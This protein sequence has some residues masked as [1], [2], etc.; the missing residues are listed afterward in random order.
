MANSIGSATQSQYAAS[1]SLQRTAQDIPKAL[2]QQLLPQPVRQSSGSD[3]ATFSSQALA[4]L[5][6]EEQTK[7]NCNL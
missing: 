7:L 1:V 5:Q 6:I 4:A 3:S 2:V